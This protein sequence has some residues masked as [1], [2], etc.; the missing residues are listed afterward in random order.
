MN[1][2]L[3]LKCGRK[4]LTMEELKQT[5][6][7]CGHNLFVDDIIDTDNSGNTYIELGFAGCHHCGK[8]Y[9]LDIVYTLSH[10]IIGKE[11]ED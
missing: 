4:G 8:T 9:T 7:N 3:K 2:T 10:I 6:P 1:L 11:I 5:C